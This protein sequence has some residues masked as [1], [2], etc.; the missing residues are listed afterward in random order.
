LT[1]HLHTLRTGLAAQAHSRATAIRHSRD[2]GMRYGDNMRTP[3]MREKSDLSS[4]SKSE[5]V[6]RSQ[7]EATARGPHERL[8][9]LGRAIS[10]DAYTEG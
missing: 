6:R 2:G 8:G 7:N 5:V 10:V 4:K 3:V 9:S 1:V